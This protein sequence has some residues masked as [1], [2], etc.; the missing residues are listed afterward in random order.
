[1]TEFKTGDIVVS[2]MM[3]THVYKNT[4]RCQSLDGNPSGRQT[5]PKE[6]LQHVVAPIVKETLTQDPP[7]IVGIDWQSRICTDDVVIH[8]Q[9][10][11]ARR[12]GEQPKRHN[13]VIPRR[14]LGMLMNQQQSETNKGEK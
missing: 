9:P 3:V 11:G 12:R 4:V 13:V 1:M 10:G 5:F 8:W 2:P 6:S 7:G 14:L